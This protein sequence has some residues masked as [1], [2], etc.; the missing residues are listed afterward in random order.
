MAVE[1]HAAGN[2]GQSVDVSCR[3]LKEQEAGERIPQRPAHE[4]QVA[5]SGS[6]S[7]DRSPGV[8][9]PDGRDRNEQACVRAGRIPADDCDAMRTADRSQASVKTQ[10]VLFRHPGRDGHVH[11]QEARRR[12]HGGQVAQVRGGGFVSEVG[13]RRG[14]QGKMDLVGEQIC[15]EHPLADAATTDDRCVV[16]DPDDDVRRQTPNARSDAIDEHKF[17]ECG[18]PWTHV[19][20]RHLT[21]ARDE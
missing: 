15:R 11:E 8:G 6:L 7:L 18:G 21:A 16:A 19:S 10:Y 4:E 1:Q 3:G 12:S 20:A 2:G 13:E 14:G 9:L 17:V 5:N